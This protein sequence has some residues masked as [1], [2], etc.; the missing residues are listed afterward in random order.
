MRTHNQLPRRVLGALLVA[1]AVLVA[2]CGGDDPPESA[3]TPA[4]PEAA[5]MGNRTSYPVTIRNCGKDLTI[6]KPPERV[7]AGSGGLG[8]VLA[9]LGVADKLVGFFVAPEEYGPLNPASSGDDYLDELKDVEVLS[10]GT[11][12][13]S[14]EAVLAARPDFVYSQGEAAGE[15]GPS[16]EQYENAGITVF[17]YSFYC[18][19]PEDQ[20]IE[21]DLN[22]IRDLGIIFDAQDRADALIEKIRGQVDAVEKAVAGREEVKTL[23]WEAY[24]DEPIVLTQCCL[25]HDVVAKAGGEALFRESTFD[26]PVSK[27]VIAAS[28]AEAVLGISSEESKFKQYVPA[29]QRVI[30]ET[31]AVQSGRPIARIPNF[32]GMPI[33]DGDHVE[34]VARALHPDAFPPDAVP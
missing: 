6:D 28:D 9:A 24:T 19:E 13:I 11:G 12:D 18:G 3:G 20:S 34:T 10:P 7:A 21:Q 16:A 26:E 8:E 5:A 17:Q 23:Y 32:F 1:L 33:R 4:G 15:G 14:A 25:N 30:S 29:M 31:P 22:D 27:E 2:G